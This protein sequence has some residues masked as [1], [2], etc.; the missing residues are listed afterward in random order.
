MKKTTL[1]LFAGLVLL[2]S[3][4]SFEACAVSPVYSGQKK[5]AKSSKK[6][7]I[8]YAKRNVRKHGVISSVL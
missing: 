1:I 3:S 2:M 4:H 5:I 7:Q 6:M 8:H